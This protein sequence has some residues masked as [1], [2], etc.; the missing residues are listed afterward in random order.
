VSLDAVVGFDGATI[1]SRSP[2][3]FYTPAAPW[4]NAVLLPL[5][6]AKLPDKARSTDVAVRM[7]VEVLEGRLSVLATAVGGGAPLDEVRVAAASGPFDIELVC[8]PLAECVGIIFRNGAD[9]PIAAQVRIHSVTCVELGPTDM[10]TVLTPP[11]GLALRPVTAWFRYYGDLGFGTA[12]RRR[13]ARYRRHDA[14]KTMPWLEGLLVSILPND[15]LSK[16]L[17]VS[18]LYEPNTMLALRRL[19]RPGGTFIDVGA[20]VGLFSMI[21]AAWVGKSG[22]V[23]SAEPSRRE[24]QRLSENLRLNDLRHV[25]AIRQALGDRSG[26][27]T[28]RVARFPNAGQNTL[29]ASFGNS[30]VRAERL[31]TVE[32][33]TLDQLVRDRGPSCVDVVK[34][35]VEGAEAAALRGAQGVLRDLRPALIV[36]IAPAALAQ[37]QSSPAEV[38]EQLRAAGY[39]MWRIDSDATLSPLADDAVGDEGNIVALPMERS[40]SVELSEAR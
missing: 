7:H 33:T 40:E 28:L 5:D 37:N 1:T 3:T 14:V 20:N 34:L 2:L 38:L 22:R 29:G 23:Y 18:G 26:T 17:Y 15:D 12:E 11:D 39:T 25:T 31:E 6:P 16:A 19:L 9:E 8:S 10:G 4:S 36:E 35:D 24:F 30:G 13:I 32:V 27:A 21:A